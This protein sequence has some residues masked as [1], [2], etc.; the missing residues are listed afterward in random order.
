[1]ILVQT[2]NWNSLHSTPFGTHFLKQFNNNEW[3]SEN[4]ETSSLQILRR[5]FWR[6][7]NHEFYLLDRNTRQLN[8][9]YP[10]LLHSSRSNLKSKSC[11]EEWMMQ[12]IQLHPLFRFFCFWIFAFSICWAV[13]L[14]S[15]HFNDISLNKTGVIF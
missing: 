7:L 12:N 14:E 11:P 5:R 9:N 3:P 10:Y 2:Q 13:K 4:H 6:S 15:I 1:M 8:N